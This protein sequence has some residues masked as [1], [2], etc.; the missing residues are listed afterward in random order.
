MTTLALVPSQDR[1]DIVSS[2]GFSGAVRALLPALRGYAQRLTHNPAASDDLVQDTLASAWKARE[3]FE[4]GTNLKA[5]LFRI[6]RNRFLT[7]IQRTRREIAWDPDLHERRLVG[8]ANQEQ[9]LMLDD[10]RRAVDQLP[11]GYAD[12]LRLVAR[13]GLSYEEAA[14]RLGV[15]RGTIGCQIHRA[16]MALLQQV[17]GTACAKTDEAPQSSASRTSKVHPPGEIYARWKR[18]GS[19]MIG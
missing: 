11:D 3:R 17:L 14:E 13:D 16:R 12:A 19:R 6:L 1:Q 4:P 2:S 10:L 15:A 9:Q 5:W 7:E 8:P 18:S